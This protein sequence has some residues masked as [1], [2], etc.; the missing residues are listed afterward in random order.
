[1]EQNLKNDEANLDPLDFEKRARAGDGSYAVA[2]GL[3]RLS[4]TQAETAHA[5]YKLGLPG[6][7]TPFG[8]IEVLAMEVQKVGICISEI[9][10]AIAEA[11]SSTD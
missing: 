3:I 6:A 9:A 2:Y 10:S 7:S 4:K 1:L 11:S 5:I 8:A